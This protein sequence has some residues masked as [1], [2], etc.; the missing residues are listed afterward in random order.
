MEREFFL[1]GERELKCKKK[2]READD[3]TAESGEAKDRTTGVIMSLLDPN[4]HK[5]FITSSCF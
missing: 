3:N 5:K 1:R 2:R 4:L